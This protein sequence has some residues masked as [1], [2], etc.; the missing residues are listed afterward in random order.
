MSSTHRFSFIYPGLLSISWMCDVWF[1]LSVEWTFPEV[2][3]HPK[4]LVLRVS[5]P[6][7]W[8]CLSCYHFPASCAKPLP[9]QPR[10]GTMPSCSARRPREGLRQV[11]GPRALGAGAP[12]PCKGL[13]SSAQPPGEVWTGTLTPG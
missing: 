10:A 8:G 4:H 7:L 11:L 9:P 3:L 13:A 12:A 5:S 6:L 2:P 1:I